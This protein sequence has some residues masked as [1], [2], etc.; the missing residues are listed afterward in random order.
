[1]SCDDIEIRITIFSITPLKAPG[2]DGLHAIFYQSQ[3]DIVG[4]SFCRFIK[5]IFSCGKVPE[6]INTTLL[7]LVPKND[8]PT[9]LKMFRPISLCT[10]AYK[11]VTKIIANRLQMLLSQL[12]GPHQTSFVPGRHIVENVII[13]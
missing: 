13:A 12:I 11:T 10:V 3:W 1:M 9:S 8:N 7:V 2:T 4:P 6:E 5:D